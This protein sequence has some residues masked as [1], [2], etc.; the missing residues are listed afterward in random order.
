[1]A[2]TTTTLTGR[3]RRASSSI[4]VGGKLTLS[5]LSSDGTIQDP[6]TGDILVSTDS[7]TVPGTGQVSWAGIP[8]IPQAGI[9]PSDARYRLSFES[10]DKRDG[11]RWDVVIDTLPSGTV[12]LDDLVDVAGVP[13]T[14]TVAELVFDARDEA[15]AAR[16]EAV[17][18][19]GLTNTDDAFAL[20]VGQSGSDTRTAVDARVAAGITGKVSKGELMVNVKDYGA[21][22]NGVADDAPA[23]QAAINAV[24]LV[25]GVVFFPAG[26]YEVATK[27]Y[28]DLRGNTGVPNTNIK[29]VEFR[30]S[31]R[32]NT[33][34]RAKTDN[35][36]AMHIQGDNPLT[37]A[38]HAYT[39]MRDISFSG[40]SPTSRTT[41]GLHLQDIAYFTMDSVS[42]HNL[43]A[44]MI[45]TGALACSF[46]DLILNESTKGV[47]AD[48]GA[49]GP[50]SNL[51]SGCEFRTL[52]DMAYDGYASLSGATF[53]NCRFEGCGTVGSSPA[54]VRQSTGGTAGEHG[55]TFIGCYIEGNRGACDIL[56]TETGS[57]RVSLN[58]IG[59]CFN[60]VSSTNFTTNNVVTSGDVDVNLMGNTFTSY[61]TYVPD[62]GR[63]YLALGATSRMRDVGNR[64]ED[65][66]ES[67][68]VS[69]G[70][71]FAGFVDG[72]VG[73]S[74]A[75]TSTLPPQWS[76]VQTSTGLFTITHNLGHTDYAVT[77]T[78]CG[79]NNTNVQRVIKT[80][81]TFQ[82]KV[83][84]TADANADDDFSFFVQ[85][86]K[87]Q[88]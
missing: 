72:S 11:F 20:Y 4:G 64:W 33:V 63:K 9:E 24:A 12:Y 78:A 87:P 29:R 8:S 7:Y 51:W 56:I 43:D 25:G 65:P 32:G 1:M 30:G 48:A 52:T 13:I 85:V 3:F 88:R 39:T 74:V 49:S 10:N 80:A 6:A 86:L 27:L 26:K 71:P 70:L 21:I 18:I 16:D 36:V 44:C 47:V 68:V 82:V 58:L 59:N 57:Q 5:V 23:I 84:T 77:A 41:D 38:S 34:I 61:N 83:V 81:N 69:Q 31:G 22:G 60:R 55:M 75:A 2:I 67:P 50:H 35:M 45:L 66:I 15:V 42:F 28:L 37:S 40:N 19:A 54:I 76:V 17:A 46:R 14:P 53:L 62:A 73:A 79:T